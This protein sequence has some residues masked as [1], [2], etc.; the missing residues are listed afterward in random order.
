MTARLES[1]NWGAGLG[2]DLQPDEPPTAPGEP[3][4]GEAAPSK[5]SNPN[6]YL[7]QLR[8]LALEGKADTTREEATAAHPIV[9]G[10]DPDIIVASD[11]QVGREQQ[12]IFCPELDGDD[13]DDVELPRVIPVITVSGEELAHYLYL[14]DSDD[15]VD[16]VMDPANFGSDHS[17]PRENVETAGM[18]SVDE[19][20]RALLTGSTHDSD[21]ISQQLT[22]KPPSATIEQMTEIHDTFSKY[23]L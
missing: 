8:R 4:P 18:L 23:H 11:S 9:W 21:K 12:F 5:F 20:W 10:R 17:D 3:V 22:P 7:K 2:L 14:Q 6:K 16:A 13:V 19:Q 1:V 15:S